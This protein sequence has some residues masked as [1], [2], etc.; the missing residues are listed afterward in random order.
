MKAERHEETSKRTI[1]KPRYCCPG[2]SAHPTRAAALVV[3]FDAREAVDTTAG[4]Q[5][6]ELL[7]HQATRQ[8]VEPVQRHRFRSGFQCGGHS[9]DGDV[10]VVDVD[11]GKTP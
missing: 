5:E 11:A 3:R 8:H 10:G 9:G 2:S 1:M 6:M 4:E 7:Q